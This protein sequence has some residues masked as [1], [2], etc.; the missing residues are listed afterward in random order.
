MPAHGRYGET[1]GVR[2]DPDLGEFKMKCDDCSRRGH[3]IACYWPITIEFWNPTSM[4]RCRACNLDRKRRLEREARRDNPEHA[5]RLR[6]KNRA[7]YA[8][9]RDVLSMKNTIRNRN[10]RE[11]R[12]ARQEAEE[13]TA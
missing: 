8:A 12:R 9:N 6:E 5:G 10:W 7:Y 4:Q 11:Q 2:W 3:G 13:K 1:R